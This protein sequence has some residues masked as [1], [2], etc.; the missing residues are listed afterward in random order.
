MKSFFLLLMFGLIAG[1]A[2]AQDGNR[3]P[4]IVSQQPVVTNEDESVTILMSHL[5]VE[6][7]DD[8]FYPWG[9]TMQVYPGD[10]YSLQG[11][12]VTPARDF[13]G[14]LKVPVTVND[15][16]DESNRFELNITVNP[17]NDKP[18]I[19]GQ[20]SLTTDEN[21]AI[22][23]Q[24]QHLQVTDPD[25]KYPD[26]FTL[27]IHPGSNY[28]VSGTQVVP[29]SGFSGT[30]SVNVTV[31]DG[32]L[33][34]EM[35]AMVVTVK[36]VNRVPEITGQSTLQVDEDQSLTLQLTHLTVVDQDSNYPQGFSLNV[37]SGND[38]SVS[39]TTVAP[40]AN[41]FG[42][43]TVPVTV[44]DGKNTSKPFNLS[45]TVTPVDDVPTLTSLETEPI[46]YRAGDLSTAIT[47]TVV[48]EEVD[49]D[50]VMFAEIGFSNGYQ[51]NVDKLVYTPVTGSGIRGVFEPATGVLT[52]IGQG[53][54]SRYTQALRSVSYEGLAGGSDVT[55][56]VYLKVNDGK[57][58]SE[59]VERALVYGEASVSL[60]IP[61]AFTPNGDLSNDTWKIVPLK[62]Q[63]E[64]EQASIRIYNKAG[65]LVFEAIGFQ[66]EWDGKLNGE[67]L[68]ADVYF[69]TIDLNTNTPEGF[70]KGLVTILR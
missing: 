63:E 1:Q 64:F 28:S 60:D 35:Y 27:A 31:H 9:F 19:T 2:I 34:S 58:D 17:V 48:I 62:G 47:Q 41:F 42:R 38:Y 46:F 57:S 23:I 11:Y 20:S 12:I 26:D 66:N 18:V 3:R 54:P 24:P 15:G 13:V 65:V 39:G 10:N 56:T 37:G 52:L 33:E 67:L 45:I 25:N 29:A 4:K 8:W 51:T 43:L 44:N 36:P 30:L 61:T 68:P 6:D 14:T 40:N 21:V 5:N 22:S 49:G 7:R 16:Q 55:K 53:S 69:Y 32:A 50:S 59:S 70:V